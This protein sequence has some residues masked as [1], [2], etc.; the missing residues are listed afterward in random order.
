MHFLIHSGSILSHKKD[1]LKQ[2]RTISDAAIAKCVATNGIGSDP[3]TSI[4]H[5]FHVLGV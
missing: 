4:F 2:S 1:R 3:L 5:I